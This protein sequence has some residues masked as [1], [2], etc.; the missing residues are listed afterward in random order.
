[1]MEQQPVQLILPFLLLE[2][3]P[4]IVAVKMTLVNSIEILQNVWQIKEN[5]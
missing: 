5:N 1:M 4:R 2:Q 3:N